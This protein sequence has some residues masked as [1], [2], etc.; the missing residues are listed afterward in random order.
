MNHWVITIS[1]QLLHLLLLSPRLAIAD[2][3][4]VHRHDEAE[5]LWEKNLHAKERVIGPNDPTLVVHLQNLATAYAVSGKY[6]ECVP[7]LRRSLKLTT[8]NLGPNAPQVS[9]PLECLAT[10][11]HHT[12]RQYAFGSDSAIVGKLPLSMHLR[13]QFLVIYSFMFMP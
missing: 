2:S 9:V 11:L 3:S 13:K 5:E 4:S 1:I 12:G 7:L 10:A 8:A 6:E